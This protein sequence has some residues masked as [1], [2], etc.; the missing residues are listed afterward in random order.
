[1]EVPTGRRGLYRQTRNLELP[2]PFGSMHG[3]AHGGARAGS[4][5]LN[6]GIRRLPAREARTRARGL[7]VRCDPGLV[8]RM[9]AS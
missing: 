4:R 7:L 6:L 5:T 2:R 3:G 8:D 1:M 9:D